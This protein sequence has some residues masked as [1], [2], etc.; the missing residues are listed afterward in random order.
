VVIDPISALLHAGAP[1]ET[2]AMLLRTIDFLK[3]EQITALMTSLTDPAGPLEQSEL[4]V[5]SLIDAWV[6][7][8]NIESG[9]ER[10]RDLYVLKARGLAHSNQIR[11]FRLTEHGVDLRE[12]Y[13]GTGGFVTGSARIAEESR[14]A[15]EALLI[16]QKIERRKSSLDHKR[17]ALEAQI[18]ALA[19]KSKP[20][21]R[22][23]DSLSIT[24]TYN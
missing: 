19:P 24:S 17:K 13:G 15:S 18:A 8:R 3:G 21:S 7:L 4:D 22:K 2:T 6:L 20:K 14:G 10:N 1:A 12:V 16:R 23:L 11:E 5:S 9:G